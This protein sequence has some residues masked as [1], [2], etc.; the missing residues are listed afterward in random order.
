[1]TEHGVI[2]PEARWRAAL[3]DGRFLIQRDTI[4]GTSYFPPRLA[5]PEGQPLEWVEA[6]GRG[7][8]YSVSVIHPK[9]P[10]QPYNVVLVDLE[11]GARMMSRV[12]GSGP[13]KI[14]IGTQVSAQIVQT[15]SGPQVV[16]HRA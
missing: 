11:E 15:E 16:F 13:D 7:T 10:Q 5:G 6:S 9:P 2:S 14:V 8:V 3:A 4:D 1:M 12:D